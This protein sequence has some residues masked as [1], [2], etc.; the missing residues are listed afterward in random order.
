M[1]LICL[2]ALTATAL[3]APCHTSQRHFVVH[4]P[5]ELVVARLMP[6][7]NQRRIYLA[8]D[9]ELETV[10]N[11]SLEL[12]PLPLR[13]RRRCRYCVRLPWHCRRLESIE[14]TQIDGQQMVVTTTL[15]RSDWKVRRLDVRIVLTR[16]GARRTRVSTYAT[17]EVNG[18]GRSFGWV[19]SDATLERLEN[20]L[21]WATQDDVAAE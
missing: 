12:F 16:D 18:L 2:A 10:E 11:E 8:C 21:R 14:R 19:Y 15:A 4:E 5:Y 1:Q 3:S 9:A 17:M 13:I 6:D 20:G 7:E